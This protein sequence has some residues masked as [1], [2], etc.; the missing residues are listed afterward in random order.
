MSITA[1]IPVLHG[2]KDTVVR[3]EG[4]ALLVRR[5]H[6][7]THIPLKAVG[8]VVA[9]GRTVTI[10][11]T[12]APAT[13]T[14]HVHRI[15]DVDEAAAASFAEAV[16]AAL[17]ERTEEADGADLVSGERLYQPSYRNWIRGLKRGALLGT[18]AA[19]A[20]CVL[21]GVTGHPVAMTAIIPSAFFAIPITALG[22]FLLFEPH[23]E[24][25]LRKHGVRTSA[26]RLRGEHGRYAYTDPGG[27]IRTVRSSEQSWNIEAAYDPRD[28]GR[29]APLR[30][31]ARRIRTAA[32]ALS[33][34]GVGLLFTAGAVGSVVAA[35]LGFFEG[36]A[37][38]GTTSP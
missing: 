30:S 32:V 37:W 7:E 16:N 35:F 5:P 17:P 29:V 22:A 25:H 1:P 14:R 27:V 9:E 18:L 26:I 28:P 23:E 3:T 10:E 2:G 11:L 24:R 34:L 15:W 8:R 38:N 19:V 6:E 4:E 21:V 33:V 36:P 13:V 12:T 31:R 20:L